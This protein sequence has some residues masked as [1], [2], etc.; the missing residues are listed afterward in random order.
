MAR[1][2]ADTVN[3]WKQNAAGAQERYTQGVASTSIDV[4]ARAIAQA[5]AAAANYAQAVS[6]GRWARAL[7]ASGGTANWKAQ[8][9]KKAGNYGT[10]IAAGEDKFNAAMSKLLPAIEQI[11]GSLPAR[12]PGNVGA[13]LQRVAALATALHSRKGEFKG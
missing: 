5:P 1:S 3:K 13:N 9:Q 2:L 6:S 8:T 10:G 7:T 4:V 12:Q 11:V